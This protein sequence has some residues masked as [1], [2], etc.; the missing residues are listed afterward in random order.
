MAVSYQARTSKGLKFFR[1]TGSSFATAVWEH[2]PGISAW[3]GPNISKPTITVTTT[4]SEAVEKISDIPD[5]GTITFNGYVDDLC[6]THQ[7]LLTQDLYSRDYR[8]CKVE[9]PTGT[10][11]YFMGQLTGMPLS[12]GVGAA[13]TTTY[14]FDVSG[15]IEWVFGGKRATLSW[16]STLVGTESTGVV[17]GKVNVTL[18]PGKESTA[19][20]TTSVTNDANFTAN[21]HYK[22]A[23]VPAGLVGA[24]KKV[25]DTVAEL[26]FTGAATT[27]V[28]VSNVALTFMDSA[29]TNADANLISGSTKTDIA[30]TFV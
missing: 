23:N 30:I 8:P 10:V 26:S 20:F 25:S 28:D 1:G 7:N 17:T 24:L 13:N 27:K 3:N 15:K 14:T 29:F 21:T 12:G 5:N 11:M 2:V 22:L 6:E 19:T 18:I 16:D 9:F 4:Q